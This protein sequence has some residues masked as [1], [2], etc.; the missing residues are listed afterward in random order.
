MQPIDAV[1]AMLEDLV[2]GP[3]T[4]FL[5]RRKQA[6]QFAA[7]FVPPADIAIEAGTLGGVAVEWLTPA[8]VE[9]RR[10]LFHLHGGGYVLGNPA[11]SRPFTTHLARLAQC[12][13]VSIDYRLAP[14]HPFP[15][16]VDDALAAYRALL[17]AGRAPGDIAIGGESAGGGL[18]LA[19]AIAARDAHLPMPAALALV[20]PWTDMRCE[21]PS[22]DTKASV[23]PLLTRRS[24][25]EMADAYLNGANPRDGLASPLLGDLKGLPPMLIHVGGDEVLLD[26][27]RELAAA[28][29]AQGVDAT[30]EEW[31]GMIHVWHMFHPMLPQ[32]AQA[33]SALAAYVRGKWDNARI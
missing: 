6:E 31:P 13:V 11:G 16:A 29:T 23:D 33:I 5:S 14:E 24:L 10:V 20:S 9:A 21:A 1:R 18:A 30:L 17:A 27:S 25:K 19:V 8:K 15:A 28:A 3:D 22:F 26:D 4:P 7:A 2:G 12:S 32:G